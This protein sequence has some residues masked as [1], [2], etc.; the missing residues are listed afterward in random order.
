MPGFRN[1]IR[2]VLRRAASEG[3]AA[4]GVMLTVRPGPG[5]TALPDEALLQ[6]LVAETGI[7]RAQLWHSASLATPATREAQMRGNADQG[8]AWALAVE[9]A[10]E[11]DLPAAR[12][13]LDA[14][15][16]EPGRVATYQFLCGLDAPA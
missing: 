1:T 7:V 16:P 10:T 5:G 11:E 9:A 2:A 15:L 6:R 3:R 8:V 4:G 14:A 13:L 12:R